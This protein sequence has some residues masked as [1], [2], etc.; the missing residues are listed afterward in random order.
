MIFARESDDDLASLVKKFEE[1]VADNEDKKFAV[2]VNF[3]GGEIEALKSAAAD[4][5]S[6]HKITN[7]AVVVPND[8]PNGPKAYGIPTDARTSV[9]LYKGKKVEA[10]H[11]LPAGELNADRIT[12][13]VA[14]TGKILK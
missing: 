10:S 13:I 6:T 7:A 5:A 3:I 9:F 4:F 8:Q 14:D 12:A 2:L 1:V 11:V